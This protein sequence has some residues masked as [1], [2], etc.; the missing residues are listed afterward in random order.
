MNRT[1]EFYSLRFDIEND[2]V[3]LKSLADYPVSGG[4]AEVTVSGENKDSHLGAKM[5]PSS[6]GGRLVYVSHRVEGD[7]LEIIQRS[8]VVEVKTVFRGYP[9][10]NAVSVFTEVTNITE[11]PITLEEVSSL[12]L[13]GVCGAITKPE[14]AYLTVFNQSHHGECQTVRQSLYDLGMLPGVP[15]AQRR[16]SGQ[17]VGSWSTKEALVVSGSRSVMS[18]SV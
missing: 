1:I 18:D 6:E 3:L 12:V 7:T 5:L 9:D 4:F 2:R 15:T 8:P 16:I 17:N 11:E 14:D 10:T 13:M